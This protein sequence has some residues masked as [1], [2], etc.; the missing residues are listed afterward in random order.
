METITT[1]EALD[2][3]LVEL[4]AAAAISDA[5]LRRGF[6]TF[7]MEQ[8]SVGSAD[9]DSEEYAAAQ[10]AL[11]ETIS[12]Q[13][14]SAE[15]EKTPFD[16]IAMAAKPFPYLNNGS[17]VT[18]DQLIAIGWIIKTLKLQ[19]GATVL[20]F[21]PGWGNTTLAL[22]RN[23]SR[24]TA[25]EIEQNFVDLINEQA[26]RLPVE[27]EVIQGDFMDGVKLRRSFNCVLFF[28]CFHHCAKHNELL[29]DL[30]KL[31]AE[32][33]QVA[34][35]AEPITEDFTAPWGLRLDGQ[36]LWAIRKNGWLEL[37]FTESYFI[38]SLMRRG[39]L[40]RK[41]VLPWCPLAVVYVARR[42]VQG[43]Y[44]MNHF[45][46]A[47]DENR[48]WSAP[49]TDPGIEFRF[50]AE[51]SRMT[52]RA[53]LDV[54]QVQVALANMA[55]FPLT[56][57]LRH[58]THSLTVDVPAN[59]EQDVIVPLDHDA[60]QLEVGS[61]TWNPAQAWGSADDRVVGIGVRRII[62]S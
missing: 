36:S 23:G 60:Q 17:E 9:P 45:H 55:P 19:P 22:A 18:G 2:R 3:K 15:N 43:C 50:A 56:V 40:V 33:G 24:V 53:G 30:D 44:P 59:T 49:E 7:T 12:G 42:A 5:E 35:A 62:V 8:P 13:R 10:F 58:G 32:G 57:A 1:L 47:P 21:G 14:Y 51:A 31:V 52:V 29:D 37:G 4:D 20:E 26:R 6:E 41:E 54:S 38:R 48:T 25:I 61:K 27:I 34:F 46:M 11:Y 28:E 39:W 16:P